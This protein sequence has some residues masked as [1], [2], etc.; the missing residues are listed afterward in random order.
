MIKLL[1]FSQIL[2]DI[3]NPLCV[4]NTY[5]FLAIIYSS[6][7]EPS[8]NF[9]RHEWIH[10]KTKTKDYY[11]ATGKWKK[12]KI[13]M[14]LFIHAIPALKKSRQKDVKVKSLCDLHSQFQDIWCSRDRL[15]HINN[16]RYKQESVKYYWLSFS[17]KTHIHN[18]SIKYKW[19]A[20]M[21]MITDDR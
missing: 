17:I 6:W 4:S 19:I 1:Q 2:K 18:L 21:M 10:A 15:S 20:Y 12:Q 3:W 5:R 7:W 13:W 11:L 8:L 9:F 16:D 14:W